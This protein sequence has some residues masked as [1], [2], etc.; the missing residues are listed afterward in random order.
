MRLEKR[1]ETDENVEE[2]K[3]EKRSGGEKSRVGEKRKCR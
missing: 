3:G 1:R 2:K